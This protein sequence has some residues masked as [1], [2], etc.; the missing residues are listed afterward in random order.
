LADP[1]SVVGDMV[2]RLRPGGSIVA[3]IPNV[4]HHSVVLPLLRGKFEYQPE[5]VLDRTHLRFFTNASMREM[6]ERAGLTIE[7]EE[8]LIL[9]SSNRSRKRRWKRINRLL[10]GRL[11]PFFTLQWIWRCRRG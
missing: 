9:I 10:G 4:Q 11:T 5:G 7:H 6:F 1:W 2:E 3:S 8:A